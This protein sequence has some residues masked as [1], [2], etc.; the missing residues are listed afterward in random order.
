MAKVIATN[1]TGNG[2]QYDLGITDDLLVGKQISVT[3]T[4]S[5]AIWGRG[6]GHVVEV[7]GAVRGAVHGIALG[8]G[9]DNENH[10]IIRQ[11]GVVS[12]G[13][14]LGDFAILLDSANSRVENAGHILGNYGIRITMQ[15]TGQTVVVNSGHIAAN[16]AL[17]FTETG[18]AAEIVRFINTGTVVAAYVYDSFFVTGRDLIL[19]RGL[20][21][22][23]VDLGAAN[24][25]FDGR[26][27]RF[28]GGIHLGAGN[29]VMLPG[30]SAEGVNGGEDFDTLDFRSGP[31][32]WLA[33]DGA[34][35]GKGLA[36]GDSYA[37]FEQV[38]GSLRN[39]DRLRGDAGN[40]VLKGFGGADTLI[41]GDGHDTLTGGTGRDMLTGGNGND[42]F[43][44]LKS[45]EGGDRINGFASNPGDDD[46]L[47]VDR[48]GFGGGLSAGYLASA[49]FVARADNQAQDSN[50][51]FIFRTAD[52]SLWF[53]AD[54][55]GGK[56]P[57]LLATFSAGTVISEA[58]ILIL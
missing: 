45:G 52:R 58:D 17:S 56:G 50:D 37:N 26:E 57:V 49:R 22:G 20:M 14:D 51:R 15:G 11:G 54:G 1:R 5:T 25:R 23:D 2:F 28:S 9:D 21:V 39:S 4:D 36:A 46:I 53:D 43:V 18:I 34:F 29:D 13:D 31:A 19:N 47:H 7:R 55:R 48:A 10:L 42:V 27:G 33:L 16:K 35:A 41:G 8:D 30:R 6:S 24:D 3:S 44:F 40:N 38:L 12:S 32:V